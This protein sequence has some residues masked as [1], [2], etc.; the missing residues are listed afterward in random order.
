MEIFNTLQLL[1]INLITD[2]IPAI[3]L[4]F[5]KSTSDLMDNTPEN[6]NNSSFFTPFLVAKIAIGAILKS[7]IMELIIIIL[8]LFPQ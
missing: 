5:E 3:M 1:W 7:I 2:S 6:R 4:A 8:I